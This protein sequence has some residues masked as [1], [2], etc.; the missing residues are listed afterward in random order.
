[1]HT[2]LYIVTA[3]I[4]CIIVAAGFVVLLPVQ[5][6][7]WLVRRKGWSDTEPYQFLFYMLYRGWAEPGTTVRPYEEWCQDKFAGS[8]DWQTDDVLEHQRK[9]AERAMEREREEQSK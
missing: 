2:I 4:T 3:G 1:M 8:E 9:K 7:S 5:L 6:L